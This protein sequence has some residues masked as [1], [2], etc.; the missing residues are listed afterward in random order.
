MI[1]SDRVVPVLAA[2]LCLVA[3]GE[4]Q[5]QTAA[6]AARTLDPNVQRERTLRDRE[7][8]EEREADERG[9]SDEP[10]IVGPEVGGKGDL[11]ETGAVFELKAIRFGDSAFIEPER[12]QAIASDYI[13]RP[14]KFADL[15]EMIGRINALYADRGIITARALI[16]PQT[17]EDGILR[18]RLVEGRLGRLEIKGNEHVRDA[19]IAAPLPVTQGAV[20]DVPALREALTWLNRTA[21]FQVQA[22]LRAGEAAGE[23]NVLV[24]TQEPPRFVTQAFVDNA[25]SESTGEYRL[26]VTAQVYAPLG[27]DDRLTLYAVGSEGS[28]N[29]YLGYRFPF[30]TRG[31]RIDLAYSRGDIEIVNGPFEPLDITGESDSVDLT[32]TQPF[33]RGDALWLDGY[34][35]GSRGSSI[36]EISGAALSDFSFGRYT[37]GLRVRGFSEGTSWRLQQGIGRADVENLFGDTTAVTLFDGTG[38]YIRRFGS[39]IVGQV[40]GAWQYTSEETAPSPLLFQVGGTNTVRGYPEGAL[41]GA[42]GYYLNLEARF[43]WR[44]RITP[45]T[46]VDHG[47]VDDISPDRETLSSAGAGV[48]WQYGRYLSG[49]LSVGVP[50]E[51]VLPDQDS[52][53][54]HARIAVSWPGF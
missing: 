41:A 33:L 14:V 40:R 38:A 22:A 6:E 4:G 39:A 54:V 43:R 15:N 52:V 28:K 5:A 23:T 35:S 42:R 34:V 18:V 10:V 49:D 2:L 36:T 7:A 32:V 26:G 53:R 3:A 47:L 24:Q 12:L 25:G 16:P 29:A 51:D 27:F 17:V 37:L 46:F 11:P 9:P 13:G 20:V 45:Y 1:R 48:G 19:F 50:L 31:G 8:L 44:E 21:E 30:N